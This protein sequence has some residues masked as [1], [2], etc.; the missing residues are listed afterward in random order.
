MIPKRGQTNLAGGGSNKTNATTT[1]CD[2]AIT[3]PKTVK[4]VSLEPVFQP[5]TPATIMLM[6]P[7]STSCNMNFFSCHD[8]T[9]SIPVPFESTPSI[10]GDGLAMHDTKRVK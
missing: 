2:V 8:S 9:N 1:N 10:G 7:V 4:P 3:A 6:I 5:T